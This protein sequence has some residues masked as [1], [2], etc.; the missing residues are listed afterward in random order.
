MHYN[1]A[2]IIAADTDRSI[3]KI[4]Y[5]HFKYNQR[6]SPMLSVLTI[7]STYEVIIFITARL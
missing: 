1:I 5:L 6:S 3:L 7:L 4:D 2:G